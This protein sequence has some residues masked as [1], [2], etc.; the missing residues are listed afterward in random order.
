MTSLRDLQP[1]LAALH[2][3][4]P[5]TLTAAHDGASVDTRGYQ[6]AMLVIATGEIAGAG[7][8]GFTAQESDDGVAWTDVDTD[9]LVGTVPA[10]LAATSVYRVGYR[11][12]KRYLRGRLSYVGGTSIGA[13]CIVILGNPDQRPV[14]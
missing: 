6:S 1:N 5:Q 4:E 9:D 14:A 7:D 8:F 10:T 13:A 3:I 12:Y 11:G 2:T